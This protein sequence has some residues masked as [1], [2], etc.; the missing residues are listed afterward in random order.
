VLDNAFYC[1]LDH[2]IYYDNDLLETELAN[3]GD[4]AVI[5]VLAH[6]WGH[7]VQAQL[8][9]LTSQMSI[10]KELQADCLAGVYARHAAEIGILEEGDLEEGASSL[11]E[12]GDFDDTPWFDPQAHGAPSQRYH[13]FAAGVTN[14]LRACL[15]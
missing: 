15:Q 11:F 2:S 13:A 6:E 14:G 9:L 4:F 12:K 8:G 7:L 3:G 5:T 1:G 10:A